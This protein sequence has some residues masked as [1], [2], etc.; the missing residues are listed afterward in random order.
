MRVAIGCPV[1]N[2]DWILPDWFDHTLA[3]CEVAAVEPVYV[4]VYGTSADR[5]WQV[6]NREVRLRPFEHHIVNYEEHPMD[7]LRRSWDLAR[8]NHMANLRNCLLEV[9]RY[10]GPDYFLS[11]DSDIL[12]DKRVLKNLL[13]V[14]QDPD[15]PCDAVGGKVYMTPGKSK[16]PSY[17]MLRNGSNELKRQD[18]DGTFP[19]SVIMALKLMSPKAYNVDY[20][21]NYH[22]EDIGWSLEARKAGCVLMWDG[23]ICSK[24]VMDREHINEIDPRI[25]W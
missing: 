5:T 24:H 17:A 10:V 23:R 25:G 8:Y 2:R 11:V 4:F 15:R 9:V 14:I 3:A 19:V 13:E 20:R 21:P 16:V 1:T 7:G 12:L 6:L 18:Q 22:G